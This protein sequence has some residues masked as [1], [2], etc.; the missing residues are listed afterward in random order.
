MRRMRKPFLS[1]SNTL[2]IFVEQL[3]SLGFTNTA[4]SSFLKRLDA[5]CLI[6]RLLRQQSDK[7]LPPHHTFLVFCGSSSLLVVSLLRTRLRQSHQFACP[8]VSHD[9]LHW[10]FCIVLFCMKDC[11]VSFCIVLTFKERR[12]CFCNM[13]HCYQALWSLFAEATRRIYRVLSHTIFIS[14]IC[15]LGVYS[16]TFCLPANC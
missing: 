4:N 14:I 6:S 11:T 13:R 9:Q 1:S 2:I 7:C 10:P 16:N 5:R 15:R 12:Q 8:L 3:L